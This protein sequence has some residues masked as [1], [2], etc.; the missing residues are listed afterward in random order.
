[1]T[2]IIRDA[3]ASVCYSDDCTYP[4]CKCQEECREYSLESIV[5]AAR[6]AAEAEQ[7][8]Q[9]ALVR[10]AIDKMLMDT[11]RRPMTREECGG[12]DALRQ[13]EID[14]ARAIPTE[15]DMT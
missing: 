2:N 9:T 1:M 7:K 8:R 5:D 14:A 12:L 15:G 6:H 13:A 11:L 4:E 10:T 3:V